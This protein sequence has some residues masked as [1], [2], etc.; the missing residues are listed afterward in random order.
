MQNA[1]SQYVMT[2]SLLFILCAVAISATFA[3]GQSTSSFK[4][5]LTGTVI[6]PDGLSFGGITLAF[7]KNGKPVGWASTDLRG[8]FE[9]SLPA[10]EYVAV[11]DPVNL[12]GTE[13]FIR[14]TET[15]PNPSDVELKVDPKKVCCT[16]AV[17]QSFPTVTATPRPS[18][19]PAAVATGTS[20]EVIVL[21]KMD[22][23][24]SV[25][26]AVVESGHPLLK[27]AAKA[28]AM[29][30]LFQP[31]K[32]SGEREA[33]L[34]YAFF[35]EQQAKDKNVRRYTNAFRVEVIS[36]PFRVDVSNT[37]AR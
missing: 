11:A 22:S 35:L 27:S 8:R 25:T 4:H 26:S 36:E 32:G 19:P 9:L 28:A 6:T 23:N 18:Y 21:V 15:G 7:M 37:S 12:Y 20:G 17:G 31:F 34:T 16:D 24:G 5:K 33:R 30:T 29:K 10:G 13:V 3:I 14:I 1:A 2:K